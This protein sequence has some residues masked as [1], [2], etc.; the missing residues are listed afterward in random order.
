MKGATLLVT[1]AAGFIGSHTI[2]EL[3]A[4]GFNVVGVDNYSNSQMDVI[5]RIKKLKTE[6][7]HIHDVDF[8]VHDLD[9]RH[10]ESMMQLR[11][12]ARYQTFNLAL[13]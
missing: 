2:V 1:G 10:V 12:T 7:L 9:V 6:V 3:M 13:P 11:P 4:A 8:Q 5:E